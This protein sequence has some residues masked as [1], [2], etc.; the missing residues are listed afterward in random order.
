MQSTAAT[1]EEYL[2][3]LPEDRRAAMSAVRAV[4]L[5][6]LPEGYAET[7]QY[8]MIGY[9]VPH[10]IYPPGYHCDPK[11]ALPYAHLGSQKNYMSLYL[12]GVYMHEET[13][14]WFR[15][16][17]AATGKKL[18]MGKSCVRFKKAEDLPLEV[19][20]QVIARIPAERYITGMEAVL[21]QRSR[22]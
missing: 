15:E 17:W 5:A 1:V 7:M 14:T 9:V 3:E 18:D 10:S 21:A 16:A 11:Q 8:G 22:K 2:A 19:I 4:I 12:M 6:N 20:G 13:S